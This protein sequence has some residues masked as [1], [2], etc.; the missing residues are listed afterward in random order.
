VSGAGE[1]A[2]RLAEALSAD[3]DLAAARELLSTE[4][5]R[6]AAEDRGPG[7]MVEA[8]LEAGL[9]SLAALAAE[10]HWHAV[11]ERREEGWRERLGELSPILAVGDRALVA[12][13]V[14][15]LGEEGRARFCD[16]V[17]AAVLREDPR[18]VVLRVAAYEPGGD[19]DWDIL[20]EDLTAQG[21]ALEVE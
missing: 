8:C 9:P 17:L 7:E 14:G 2:A 19:G 13:P 5:E 18:R 11:R 20:A 3:P 4:A 12:A 21:V 10:R 16:R 15:D 1:I 6:L